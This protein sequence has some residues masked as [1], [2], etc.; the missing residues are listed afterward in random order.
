[1]AEGQRPFGCSGIPEGT[2]P[3]PHPPRPPGWAGD[4]ARGGLGLVCGVGHGKRPAR[5]GEQLQIV[6]RVAEGHDLLRRPA[7]PGAQTLYRRPL[8]D[9]GGGE[10]QI[11]GEG[12]GSSHRAAGEHPFRHGGPALLRDAVDVKL[13]YR[14]AIQGGL[15]ILRQESVAAQHPLKLGGQGARQHGGEPVPLNYVLP[16]AVDLKGE[17]FLQQHPHQTPPGGLLQTIAVEPLAG[18]HVQHGGAVGEHGIAYHLHLV[19]HLPQQAPA[20]AAGDGHGGSLLRRRPQGADVARR[21]GGVVVV[22]QG[23]VHVQA[24]ESDIRHFFSFRAWRTLSAMPAGV[25]P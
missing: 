23:A 3:P 14:P 1:M 19:G 15:Q 2:P 17:L 8:V 4:I 7:P 24:D 21:H 6:A 22:Q 11:A 20:P 25:R 10:L 16:L 13:L 18:R 9:A 5:P 12:G